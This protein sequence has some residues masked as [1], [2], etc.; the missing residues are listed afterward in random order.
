M[1]IPTH[2]SQRLAT[3]LK[4]F[5]PILKS[6]QSRKA[7]EADTSLI[8]TQLLAEL[9]GY[10]M[11]SEISQQ[12]CIKGTFCDL[13]TRIDDKF[14]MIIEV[15]AIGLELKDSRVK[16]PVDYA[17]HE[18]V[19][20]VALTNGNL[21]KVFKV[22]YAKPI[23]WNLVLDIDLLNLNPKDSDHLENLYLL[24]RESMVKSDLSAY[25][26]RQQ[27]M[28]KFYLAAVIVSEP[29]VKTIR[30]ELHHL[31]GVMLK[32]EEIQTAL[33]DVINSELLEG[34][35][36]D[37]AKREIKKS[38][39]KMLHTQKDDDEEKPAQTAAIVLPQTQSNNVAEKS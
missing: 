8:A 17:A 26:D 31:K 34:E 19:D 14:K 23:D 39:A 2:V 21:W 4:K 37:E 10:D 18:A 28:N 25:Y 24:T 7:N 36:A 11:F 30:Q 5:Q 9:F 13:A 6:A 16:Q 3:G 29:V 12:K 35:K 32:I 27:V 22:T 15:K 1:A 20:W 33:E 38:T